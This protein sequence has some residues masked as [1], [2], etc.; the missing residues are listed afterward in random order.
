MSSYTDIANNAE[1]V[2]P[3]PTMNFT[4]PDFLGFIP[5]FVFPL[6]QE[7]FLFLSIVELRSEN[8]TRTHFLLCKFFFPWPSFFTHFC[9]ALNKPFWVS[10]GFSGRR[11][12]PAE[13][14]LS[15]H[16]QSVM[17]VFLNL[18]QIP[19]TLVYSSSQADFPLPFHS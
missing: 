19:F 9:R 16:D 12:E 15:F 10:N 18:T 14:N 5:T 3:R 13:T 17:F 6:L 2:D 4:E 11:R 1:F 8:S 7:L